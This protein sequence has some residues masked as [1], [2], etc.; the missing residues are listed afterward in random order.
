[1][2]LL[3][4]FFQNHCLNAQNIVTVDKTKGR[5]QVII[6]IS[7]ITQGSL[8]VPVS[9]EY[10]AKGIQVK[11]SGY[12]NGYGLGWQLNAGGTVQR[13]L[14]DLPDDLLA[15]G[16]LYGNNGSS[17]ASFAISNDNNNAS[18]PDEVI[19]VNYINTNFPK[20]KDSEPDIFSVSAP[21]LSCRIVF[22][23]NHKP[24]VIPYN[25]YKINYTTDNYGISSFTIIKDDGTQYL[26][27]TPC[28]LP[29]K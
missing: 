15:K 28:N 19:D 9:M 4:I 29:L 26:F 7:S 1:M 12:G 8:T 10:L 11:D 22:D 2:L 24:L 20:D 3:M 13:I 21:G 16:W 18:C 27:N 14:K 17:V 25:D 23:K 5:A 6:P